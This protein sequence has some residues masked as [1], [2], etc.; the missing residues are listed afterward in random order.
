MQTLP[1]ELIVEIS[2]SLIFSELQSLAS[3]CKD[4]YYMFYKDIKDLQTIEKA[5]QRYYI[6]L[7]F[8]VNY[9]T[10]EYCFYIHNTK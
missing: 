6:K 4:Y 5:L 2:K 3:T 10:E 8:S 7:I 1:N 9:D